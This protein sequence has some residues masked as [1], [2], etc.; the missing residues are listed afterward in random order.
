MT[1]SIITREIE[2]TAKDGTHLIGFLQPPL[3]KARLQV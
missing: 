2:Y 3:L 1:A